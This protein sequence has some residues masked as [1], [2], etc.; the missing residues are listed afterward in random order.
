MLKK[1]YRELHDVLGAV[2]IG[3]K[4]PDVEI[5]GMKGHD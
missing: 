4:L 5:I 3:L 2:A 1:S